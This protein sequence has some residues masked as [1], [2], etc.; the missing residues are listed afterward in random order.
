VRKH[1]L[2]TVCAAALAAWCVQL[3]YVN[4]VICFVTAVRYCG[5]AV[6]VL[7]LLLL[8]VVHNVFFFL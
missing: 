3:L 6:Q 2:A 5:E 8:T 4:W 7:L 1:V